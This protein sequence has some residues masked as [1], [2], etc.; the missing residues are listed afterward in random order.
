MPSLS[1]SGE[2]PIQ[3]CEA[4]NAGLFSLRMNELEGRYVES[5]ILEI[6]VYLIDHI[7]ANH[8]RLS[9][10]DD[11]SSDLRNMG[12]TDNEISS[13]YCWVMDRYGANDQTYYSDFP[14]EHH[15]L[16]VLTSSERYQFDTL[17]QGFLLKLVNLNLVDDEQLE[18]I[19]DRGAM[20][21][22]KPVTLDQMKLIA[23]SFVFAD[24]ADLEG[25]PWL[26]VDDSPLQVN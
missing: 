2:F 18:M 1:I 20:L 19:L 5:K 8:G 4:A 13:A 7:R 3:S 14:D 9:D 10:M 6:V 22:P 26:D 12:Y 25:F 21:G 11:V 15:S 17:A 23:S 16:R 24:S